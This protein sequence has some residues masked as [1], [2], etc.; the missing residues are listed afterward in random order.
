MGQFSVMPNPGLI[1]WDRLDSV[2]GSSADL[3]AAL[4]CRLVVILFFLV[5][6]GFMVLVLLYMVV[7]LF[8]F[9]QACS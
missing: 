3:A 8:L 2:I 5:L 6:I 4:W 7:I 9:V 1:P